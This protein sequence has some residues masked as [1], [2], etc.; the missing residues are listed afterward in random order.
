MRYK[1][2]HI[3]QTMVILFYCQNFP[4]Y[5]TLGGDDKCAC[6]P[7]SY[8]SGFVC[9]PCLAGF[10]STERG[11]TEC[12]A[13]PVRE[14]SDQSRTMCERE[15]DYYS[16]NDECVTCSEQVT[17]D[18]GSTQYGCRLATQPWCLALRSRL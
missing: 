13:C 9:A 7:G 18:Q 10:Y 5:S 17:C 15:E 11:A 12:D 16:E 4:T 6:G 1:K 2:L 3:F 14:T 8:D